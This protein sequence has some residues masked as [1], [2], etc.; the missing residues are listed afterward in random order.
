MVFL[1]FALATTAG[2]PAITI[3]LAMIRPARQVV[4]KPIDL[5]SPSVEVNQ[6]AW[7]QVGSEKGGETRGRLFTQP[8]LEALPGVRTCATGL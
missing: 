6:R 1:P 2:Q 4:K 5:S 3:S 7:S 8:A